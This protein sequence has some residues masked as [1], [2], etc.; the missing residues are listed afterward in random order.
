MR[1]NTSAFLSTLE[2]RAGG[3]A[4]IP[5][6][7]G[8][9]GAQMLGRFADFAAAFEGFGFTLP[10]LVLPETSSDADYQALFVAAG[11]ADRLPG[12]S[13]NGLALG[14]MEVFARVNLVDQIT[15]RRPIPGAAGGG[16]PPGGPA[17]RT[18]HPVPYDHRRPS[19][20]SRSRRRTVPPSGT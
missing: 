12:N 7:S 4:L 1:D 11:L 3:G 6:A 15:R 13:R 5:T 20:G 2:R 16:V 19:C 10:E 17:R 18:G 8:A 14:E 9:A